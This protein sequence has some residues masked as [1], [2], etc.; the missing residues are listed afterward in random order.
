[1]SRAVSRASREPTQPARVPRSEIARRSVRHHMVRPVFF[2]L[3]ALWGFLL[4]VAALAVALIQGGASVALDA[5]TLLALSFGSLL[6]LG[7]GVVAAG[8]YREARRRQRH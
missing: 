6:A 2:A 4:G 5:G 8:A 1:M 7:G 3:A